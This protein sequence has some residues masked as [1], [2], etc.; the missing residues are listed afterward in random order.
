MDFIPHASLP[1]AGSTLTD[2]VPRHTPVL[3]LTSCEKLPQ[4]STSTR[5]DRTPGKWNFHL[6]GRKYKEIHLDFWL[7]ACAF[8]TFT[9][10]FCS[11]MRKARLILER[12]INTMRTCIQLSENTK[13]RKLQ[14]VLLT[15]ALCGTPLYI[16][17]LSVFLPASKD[18]GSGTNKCRGLGRRLHV[19]AN[20]GLVACRQ[21]RVSTQRLNS[22]KVSDLT[23]GKKQNSSLAN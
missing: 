19:L 13:M 4:A 23:K 18:R 12:K 10:I 7:C 22:R 9:T 6:L 8:N 17:E 15:A 20:L 5:T 2:S 21:I 14:L 3:H 11:S 1:S 16:K